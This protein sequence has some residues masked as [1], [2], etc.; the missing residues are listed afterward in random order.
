MS[1]GEMGKNKE[2]N[3][4]WLFFTMIHA[5]DS[6]KKILLSDSFKQ[7]PNCMQFLSPSVADFITAIYLKEQNQTHFFK[8]EKHSLQFFCM[9]M[10]IL[11]IS[12]LKLLEP[13]QLMYFAYP[14]ASLQLKNKTPDCR[15]ISTE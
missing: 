3:Q 15:W 1:E 10:I 2:L 6:L 5:K 11:L 12:A 14:S 9:T 4:L 8:G 13:L 7:I